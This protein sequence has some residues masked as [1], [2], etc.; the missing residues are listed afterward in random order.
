MKPLITPQELLPHLEDPDWVVVDC[1]FDLTHTTKGEADYLEAHIPGAVYADLER[2]LSAAR[3][4]K[5]GR[6][7]LPSPEALARVFSKLGIDRDSTVVA[8][9]R[10]GSPYAARLWWSLRYLGAAK[11]VVLDGGFEAW[12][13]A[14]YPVRAGAEQR[15]PAD[16]V[17]SVESNKLVSGQEIAARLE[18]GKDLLLDARSPERY[19]GEEEPYDPIAGRIP[20]ASNLFWEENL[21]ATRRFKAPA[22]LREQYDRILGT[23]PASELIAYCG[24]GVNACHLLLAMEHAGIRGARLYPGSWSEWCSDPSRPVALGG[25]PSPAEPQP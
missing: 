8:Y 6:H 5:N 18:L 9:D 1:S 16:F 13:Q 17:P 14:G 21:D 11:A 15:S 24:S 3:D 25:E 2:D 12:A 7:P 23:R 4:G 10:N 20:G 19:R 22:S